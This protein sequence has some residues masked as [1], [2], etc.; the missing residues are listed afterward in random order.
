MLTLILTM[1]LVPALP[2]APP[3][4]TLAQAPP[5]M[6]ECVDSCVDTHMRSMS[7]PIGEGWTWN[8]N[9]QCWQRTIR[10]VYSQP[11]TYRVAQPTFQYTPTFSQGNVRSTIFRRGGMA[12]GSCGPGG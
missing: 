3:L 8:Q 2:Q 7:M 11:L 4:M 12:S 6:E 9:E 10:V 5:L 1:C